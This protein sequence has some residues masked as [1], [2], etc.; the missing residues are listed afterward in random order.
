MKMCALVVVAGLS[1]AAMA[2]AEAKVKTPKSE[3][4]KTAAQN[5]NVNHAQR[6]A[7]K[8]KP[9]YKYKAPKHSKKPPRI[10]PRRLIQI[11]RLRQ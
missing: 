8:F 10:R 11:D 9:N 4:A 1:L 7:K 6:S 3:N 5:G 2:P